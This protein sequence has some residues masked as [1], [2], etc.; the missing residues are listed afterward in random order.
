MRMCS[1][2]DTPHRF[3]AESDFAF[4][5]LQP[6]EGAENP[7]DECDQQPPAMAGFAHVGQRWAV[8]RPQLVGTRAQS[9]RTL[10]DA[11]RMHDG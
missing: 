7:C 6:I 10:G 1:R 9:V 3:A 5:T 4:T 2:D 11:L 8:S